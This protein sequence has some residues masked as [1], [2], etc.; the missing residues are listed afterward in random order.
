MRIISRGLG[1]HSTSFG[2][3][4]AFRSRLICQYLS[5]ATRHLATLTFT[6]W[7]TALWS[8]C[9]VCI[10]SLKFV[11]LRFRKI[12]HIYGKCGQY[13]YSNENCKLS[14]LRLIIYCLNNL[15]HLGF[16]GFFIDENWIFFAKSQWQHCCMFTWDDMNDGLSSCQIWA[17]SFSS[18]VMSRHATERQ[19]DRQRSI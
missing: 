12:L 15:F 2:L 3:S 6:L 17:F 18:G 1:N 11:C 9:S 14:L 10:P 4:V 13:G 8:S 16:S 19:T 7:V 5:D